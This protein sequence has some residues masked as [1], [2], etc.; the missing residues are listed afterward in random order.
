MTILT[1]V[2]M[3]TFSGLASAALYRMALNFAEM[4]R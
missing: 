2:L 1:F 3:M 4:M